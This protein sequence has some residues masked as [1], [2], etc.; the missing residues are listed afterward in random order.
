MAEYELASAELI[1]YPIYLGFNDGVYNPY[2]VLPKPKTVIPI[3]PGARIPLQPLPQAGNVQYSQLMMADYRQQIEAIFM[4]MPMS[5][6]D[7]PVQTATE[8]NFR[9]QQVLEQQAPSLGRLQTEL[10]NKLM[11]RIIF[12]LSQRGI[13]PQV[14]IQNKTIKLKGVNYPIKITYNTQ[15]A[16]LNALQKANAVTTLTQQLQMINPQL[17]MIMYNIPELGIYLGEQNNTDLNI[18]KPLPMI[19]QTL[20]QLLQAQV[21]GSQATGQQP[22]QQVGAL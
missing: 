13:I 10:L 6:V 2:Q 4:N 16:Q 1:A 21:A 9:A 8:I 11:D 17:P 12:V 22:Q 5:P 15:L 7:S 19:Q 3:A 14:D 18:F 20:D